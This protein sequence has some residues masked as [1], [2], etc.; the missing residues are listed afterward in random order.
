MLFEEPPKPVL[1]LNNLPK[2][3]PRL[4]RTDHSLQKVFF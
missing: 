2:Q 3:D 1:L 4:V